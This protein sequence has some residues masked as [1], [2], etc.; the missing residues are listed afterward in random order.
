MELSCLLSEGIHIHIIASGGAGNIDRV[1]AVLPKGKADAALIASI[2]NYEAYTTKQIK[3]EL[4][5]VR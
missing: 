5:A 1:Y 3:K 2:V 4:H